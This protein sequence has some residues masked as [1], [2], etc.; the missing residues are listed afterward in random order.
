[1][2]APDLRLAL[3]EIADVTGPPP[4]MA[5]VALARARHVRQ[6]RAVASGVA[7]VVALALVAVVSLDSHHG[8][9]TTR[10][11][12]GPKPSAS[13]SPPAAKRCVYLPDP[14][15]QAVKKIEP[16]YW[17]KF[18]ETT[19]ALLPHR[20][21]YVMQSGHDFCNPSDPLASVAGAVI[22]LGT[23][24]QH[25]SVLIDLY[26]KADPSEF[27][28]TCA[29]ER[30]LLDHPTVPGGDP[31]TVLSCVDGTVTSPTVYAIESDGSVDVTAVYP[32]LRAIAMETDPAKPHGP[33]TISASALRKV[34]ADPGLLALI[35]P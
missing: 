23:S 17:P 3:K 35:H 13:V 32:D 30:Y 4:G 2:N 5:D 33:L 8:T 19:I 29:S 18:V 24:R 12:S 22:N 7:A 26:A 20:T 31:M 11:A 34:V 1:M 10:V 14:D 6:R 21:D 15:N 9:S 16:A 25:A 28:S 27:E